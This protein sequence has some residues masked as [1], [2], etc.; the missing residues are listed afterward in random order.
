MVGPF[1][2]YPCPPARD[3]GSRVSGLLTLPRVPDVNT[4]LAEVLRFFPR[5]SICLEVC[6]VAVTTKSETTFFQVLKLPRKN[7][8]KTQATSEI[9]LLGKTC[10]Y[11]K[12]TCILCN[13][14][15]S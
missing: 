7:E 6:K 1:D 8:L 14:R 11:S 13:V 5:N 2:H 10:L 12:V 15:I 9:A 4:L 3:F